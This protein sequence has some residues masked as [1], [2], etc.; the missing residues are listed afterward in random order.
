[1]CRHKR[2]TNLTSSRRVK[3]WVS[4]AFLAEIGTQTERQDKGIKTNT[5]SREECRL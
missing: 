1:L 3:T 2:G 5:E 4:S